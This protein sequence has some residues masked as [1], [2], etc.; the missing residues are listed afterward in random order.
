MPEQDDSP[1]EKPKTKA[2]DLGFERDED[3]AA[4]YANNIRFETSV[5]DLKIIFG[6][7]DQSTAK[8]VVRQH[9]AINIPWAQVKLMAYFLQMNVAVHEAENGRISM[10]PSIIP[11]RPDSFA[12]KSAI[13]DNPLAQAV[14]G[15]LDVL[16]RQ[17]FRI[18]EEES[19]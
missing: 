7:L 19:S 2:D 15:H 18:G 12:D 14:L 6:L 16:H 1:I 9:T 10:P 4:L 17:F 3:F 8:T 13:S 5:W 11:P